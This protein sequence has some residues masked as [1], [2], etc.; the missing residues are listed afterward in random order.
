LFNSK[1]TNVCI[2]PKKNT[3]SFI[4]SFYLRKY[5]GLSN[6]AVKQAIGR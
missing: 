6:I 2:F 1:T 4:L 5:E 3:Y